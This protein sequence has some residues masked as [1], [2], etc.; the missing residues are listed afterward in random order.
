MA[1]SIERYIRLPRHDVDTGWVSWKRLLD[2]VMCFEAHN[3]TYFSDLPDST[4]HTIDEEVGA[5]AG[6]GV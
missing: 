1:E 2:A 4:Y 5:A 6:A 3:L